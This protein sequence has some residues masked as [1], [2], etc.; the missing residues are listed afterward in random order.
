[1]NS[2]LFSRISAQ[3]HCRSSLLLRLFPSWTRTVFR[4]AHRQAHRHCDLDE[5]TKPRNKHIYTLALD[6]YQDGKFSID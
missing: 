3:V 2:T 6:E 5:T 1:M 4:F